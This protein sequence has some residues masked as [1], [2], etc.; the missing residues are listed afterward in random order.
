MHLVVLAVSLVFG[1]V[2]NL[3]V[4]AVSLSFGMM[5][6]PRWKP[7]IIEQ[8]PYLQA[9][10]LVDRTF[11][12]M[13]WASYHAAAGETWPARARVV[14]GGVRADTCFVMTPPNLQAIVPLGH[15]PVRLEAGALL[16][17]WC[18][19]HDRRCIAVYAGWRRGH[20]PARFD[21]AAVE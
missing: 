12:S 8:T 11:G 10:R 19:R 17:K 21:S 15:G 5:L 1:L 7:P 6:E 2:A 13:V 4:L 20:A 14:A 3:V 16:S 9:D 18:Q